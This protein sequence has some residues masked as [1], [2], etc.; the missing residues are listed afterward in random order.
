MPPKA[1]LGDQGAADRYGIH[2]LD[3]ELAR[4]VGCTV[5]ELQE[6]MTMREWVAWSRKLGVE[7]QSRELAAKRMG[8]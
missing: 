7:A 1:F 4:I 2:P 8:A 5:A 6:R 3:F